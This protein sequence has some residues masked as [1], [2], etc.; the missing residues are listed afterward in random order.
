MYYLIT[1]YYSNMTVKFALI[2]D[3]Y[4]RRDEKNYREII[5]NREMKKT[6]KYFSTRKLL[7]QKHKVT[8][9]QEHKGK[10]W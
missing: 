10:R 6:S 2:I 1:N 5:S 3:C 4:L 7:S 8:K 9:I